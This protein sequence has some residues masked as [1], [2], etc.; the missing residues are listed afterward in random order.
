MSSSSYTVTR[1]QPL[2]FGFSGSE[3]RTGNGDYDGLISIANR[4]VDAESVEYFRLQ[5]VRNLDSKTEQASA[6]VGF[7]KGTKK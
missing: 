3:L 6:F 7:K 4:G 2:G 1:M 5:S